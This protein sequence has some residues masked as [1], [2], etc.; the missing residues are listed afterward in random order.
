MELTI[1]GR[2]YLT[3]QIGSKEEIGYF[4]ILGDGEKGPD[5]HSEDI[6]NY[7]FPPNE[8]KVAI[9]RE[10]YESLE[11]KLVEIP[12]KSEI[13]QL[14]IKGTLEINVESIGIN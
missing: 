6:P 2:A 3:K 7:A 12:E 11:K 8:I 4:L 1:D 14:K 9:T 13:K 10:Q 5:I